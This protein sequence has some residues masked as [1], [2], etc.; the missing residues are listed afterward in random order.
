MFV[1]KVFSQKCS[2]T[3]VG[4]RG[5]YI[6][7]VQKVCIRYD[8]SAKQNISQVSREKALPVRHTKTSCL[9]PVLTLHILIMCRAHASLHGKLIRK[10]IA[11]TALV[12]NCLK[13]SHTL[14]LTQPLQINLTWNAGY[15]R[16]NKITIK[17]GTELKPTKTYL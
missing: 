16:L 8:S 9:N 13:S 5:I 11:K 17:F 3:Y 6:V 4:N 12:F 15:I 10:Q 1:A 7:W 14:S 2:S